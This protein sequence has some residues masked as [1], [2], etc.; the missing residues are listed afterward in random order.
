MQPLLYSALGKA[1]IKRTRD[2]WLKS[3]AVAVPATVC[4]CY[5]TAFTQMEWMYHIGIAFLATSFAL[6]AVVHRLWERKEKADAVGHVGEAG[7]SPA[8]VA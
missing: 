5:I 8:H 1:V 2:P 3:L 7:E 4:T 6:A